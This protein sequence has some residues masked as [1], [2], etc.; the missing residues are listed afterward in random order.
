MI[1]PDL[2]GDVPVTVLTLDRPERRNA[3]T[4]E[5][6]R[7]LEDAVRAAADRGDRALVVQGA[8]G[9]FC[10]G[11]DLG[12]VDG[13]EYIDALGAACDALV[14]APLAAIAAVE[15]ACL[16]AGLQVAL[17]CDLVV[18]APTARFGIPAARLGLMVDPAT[19]LRLSGRIGPGRASA[20]LLAADELDADGALAAGLAQ[21]AGDPADAV[22]WARHIAGL[23][24]LTVIGHKLALTSADGAAISAAFDRVWASA[25]R[26][27]GVRA[28][29]ERRPPRFQGR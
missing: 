5:G 20:L 14:E 4:V 21:R 23:A 12:T 10:A 3:L 27:E 9:H 26:E 28:F 11:A 1:R 6:C 18:V 16:G 25:D 8:G 22:A 17:A 19:A 29:A 2:L 13:G 15:G 7:A 24:P